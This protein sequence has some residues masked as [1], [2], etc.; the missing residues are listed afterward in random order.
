MAIGLISK[1]TIRAK[2]N[3]LGAAQVGSL[4][5][6][7]GLTPLWHPT[8]VEWLAQKDQDEQR[9]K[10]ALDAKQSKMSLSTVRAAWIAVGVGVVVGV[11]TLL[12]WVWPHLWG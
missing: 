1:D 7:G 3:E 11:I 9:E 4:L 5:S 12:A 8:I 10:D 6:A 2:L